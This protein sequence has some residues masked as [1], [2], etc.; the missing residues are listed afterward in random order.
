MLTL[1]GA[2]L[3]AH[4]PTVP[5]TPA[6]PRLRQQAV[7]AGAALGLLMACATSSVLSSDEDPFSARLDM[8]GMRSRWICIDHQR[9]PVTAGADGYASVPP[10]SRVTIGVDPRDAGP[11]GAR[12]VSAV[13][14][15][16]RAG[17]AYFASYETAGGQCGLFVYREVKSNRLGLGVEP[18]QSPARDCTSRQAGAAPLH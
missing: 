18:T 14:F 5:T 4:G 7:R 15:V 6:D 11:P 13:S 9:V 17:Q 10:G 3:F 2:H 12:C 16:P 1:P 8:H